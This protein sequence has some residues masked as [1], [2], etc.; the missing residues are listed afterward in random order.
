IFAFSIFA[1]LG[2]FVLFFQKNLFGG[3][4]FTILGF[5]PLILVALIFRLLKSNKVI[6]LTKFFRLHKIKFF[7]QNGEESNLAEKIKFIREGTIAFFQKSPKTIF[8]GIILSCFSFVMR[9]I[10]VVIFVRILGEFIPFTN[11]LLIRIL[12]LFS[13]MIPIPAMLGVYEGTNILAFQSVQLTAETG[14]SFTLMTR[15]I[16]FSF[17]FVGLLIIAYYLTHHIFKFFNGKNNVKRND[18]K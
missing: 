14:I 12:T 13:G 3:L 10:Q 5:L 6:G 17:V 15:L 16:D 11:A 18:D 2:V 1:F 8:Y 4:F 9:A 7:Q